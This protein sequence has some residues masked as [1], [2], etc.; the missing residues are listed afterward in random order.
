[1]NTQKVI[2]WIGTISSI[3]GA[4][5]MAFGIVKLGYVC[6]S[7]GSI[8][9]L[10]IGVTKKDNPLIILNGTFFVANI[11]GLYRAFYA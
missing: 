11:I 1:M 3:V 6:F 7:L 2:S 10:I 8:S 4:F 9:W 5:L